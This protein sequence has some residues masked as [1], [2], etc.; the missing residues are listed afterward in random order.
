VAERFGLGF[1]PLAWEPVEIAVGGAAVSGLEPLLKELRRTE[2]RRR[3]EALGG[4][5]LTDAG[6]AVRC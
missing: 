6:R 2:V 5:D 4:Y 3:I 1:V